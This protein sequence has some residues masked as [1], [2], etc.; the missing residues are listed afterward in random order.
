VSLY[1]GRIASLI[2]TFCRNQVNK[3]K[4]LH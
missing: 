3:Q 4:K 1:V 2:K